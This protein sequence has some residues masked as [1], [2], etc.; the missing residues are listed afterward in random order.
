M[1]HSDP[2]TAKELAGCRNWLRY[3]LETEVRPKTGAVVAAGNKIEPRISPGVAGR[4]GRHNEHPCAH[5]SEAGDVDRERIEATRLS[6]ESVR[7]HTER[8]WICRL[9]SE[10]DCRVAEETRDVILPGVAIY[11]AV[12]EQFGFNELR[13]STRGLRF[14][15]AMDGT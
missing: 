12:M 4:H 2:P 7:W 15:A 8:L 5:G 6:L 9:P 10:T 11:E 14:A 3:F 1:P 13:V